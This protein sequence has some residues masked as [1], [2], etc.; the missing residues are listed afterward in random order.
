MG[1]NIDTDVV[2]WQESRSYEHLSPLK[3]IE[4][5]GFIAVNGAQYDNRA[6]R[7]RL[8]R[9]DPELRWRLRS[10]QNELLRVSSLLYI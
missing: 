4:N 8:C 2:L 3:K 9:D 7:S 1:L 10:V 6:D 5:F